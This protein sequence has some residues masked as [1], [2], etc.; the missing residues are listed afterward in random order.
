MTP[1]KT[2]STRRQLWRWW[3]WLVLATL[4][5]ALLGALRYFS[6]VD[7]DTAPGSLLFRAAM[8][9]AHFAALTTVLL[10]P[11]LIAALLLPRPRFI[12]PIGILSST[13]IVSVLLI[14]TQIYRLYRFHINGGVLNLLFGGAARETFVF[15]LT[16]YV[17]ASLIAAVVL[18]AAAAAGWCAW[19]HVR[20]S[21]PGHPRFVQAALT[22]VIVATLGFHGVHVWADVVSKEALLEQTD[23]LPL[24]YAAT[25]KRLLRSLGVDVRRA[26]APLA[27]G[28]TTAYCSIR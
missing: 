10:L 28:T 19:R 22:L 9:L 27:K 26:R 21:S 7:L 13:L 12:L 24:R 1:A 16:M 4:L 25:A 15:P 18:G 11:V 3:G 2:Q 17:Q 20:R 8:L 5:L 6:V 23:V 14:D